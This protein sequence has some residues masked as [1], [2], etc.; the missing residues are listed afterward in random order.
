MRELADIL[1]WKAT[2]GTP[3]LWRTQYED[4]LESRIQSVANYRIRSSQRSP[5][6]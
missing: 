1:T 2:S 6:N 5:G 4:L 3:A